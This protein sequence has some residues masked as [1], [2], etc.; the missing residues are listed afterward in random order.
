LNENLI[1][2]SLR[3]VWR[4]KESVARKYAGLSPK[5]QI[6]RMNEDAEKL[7]AKYGLKLR[8]CSSRRRRK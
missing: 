3:E 6:R 2:E 7:M 4:W 5:E 1:S 8:R